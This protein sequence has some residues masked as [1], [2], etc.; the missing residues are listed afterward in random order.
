MKIN[1]KPI[2]RE[3]GEKLAEELG[4]AKYVECSAYTQV[5]FD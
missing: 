1:A 2:T 5:R 3:E 4:A